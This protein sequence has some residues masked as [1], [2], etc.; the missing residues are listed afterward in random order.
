[1]GVY[2]SYDPDE[3]EAFAE[4]S[5]THSYLISKHVPPLLIKSVKRA[6]E[7]HQVLRMS[8]SAWR[9]AGGG[10]RMHMGVWEGASYP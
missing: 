5:E 7:M 1:M 3:N 9:R 6:K 10:G 8:V 4:K 2:I